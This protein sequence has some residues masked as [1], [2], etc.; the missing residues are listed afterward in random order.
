MTK[1]ITDE[2][3]GPRE[4]LNFLADNIEAVE[5]LQ[6]EN[7]QARELLKW[8]MACMLPHSLGREIFDKTR[9]FLDGEDDVHTT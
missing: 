3:L 5:R 4:V 6:K 7:E 2:Q 8:W 9:A 1:P